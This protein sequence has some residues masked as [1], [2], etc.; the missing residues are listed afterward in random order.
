M[1]AYYVPQ[2]QLANLNADQVF[3]QQLQLQNMSGEF[4][5]TMMSI[6]ALAPMFQ[7]AAIQGHNGY[8]LMKD[9]SDPELTDAQ[10]I[11]MIVA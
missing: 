10:K 11:M 1:Q 8:S 9:H 6:A 2:A 4:D 5:K 7:A 3:Q